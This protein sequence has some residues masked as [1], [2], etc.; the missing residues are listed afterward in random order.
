M[1]RYSYKPI[2]DGEGF[3]MQSGEV[4]RLAC[5]DCGLVHNVVIV[6]QDE[7]PVGVAM[8][9]NR[10]ATVLRRNKIKRRRV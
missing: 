8:E 5:C 2:I 4:F 7:A 10:K 1:S 9:R 3:E 6:S